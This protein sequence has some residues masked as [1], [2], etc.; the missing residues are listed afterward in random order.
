MLAC[1]S[2]LEGALTA[3]KDWK[4]IQVPSGLPSLIFFSDYIP[5]IG[6]EHLVENIFNMVPSL[7]T[8]PPPKKRNKE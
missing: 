8:P 7:T 3:W 2:V 6:T 5:I 1:A 4:L